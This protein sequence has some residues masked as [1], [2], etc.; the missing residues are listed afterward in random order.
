M[1]QA[2]SSIRLAQ[3]WRAPLSNQFDL[4]YMQELSAFLVQ[5]QQEGKVIYPPMNNVFA[6]FEQ[7]AFNDVKVVIIGQDPYHGEHQAHGLSFSVPEG[8]KIP[9]SLV[10]IYKELASDLGVIMPTHGNLQAWAAQG[11]LLLNAVLSVE[12]QQ[13]GSHQGKGWEQFTDAVITQ[14]NTEREHLVFI[15]WGNY[16]QRKGRHIDRQRHLVLEGVHPSPL[17]AYRGFFGCQHFSKANQYLQQ[18]GQPPIQWQ[19]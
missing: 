7:T 12:Q 13:A 10:N 5:Q 15:L 3:S 18:W 9:P 4:P 17:S 6:A 16:A 14:L 1:V 8:V 11:V 2:L 19:I